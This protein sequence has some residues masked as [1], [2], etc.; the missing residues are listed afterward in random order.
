MATN[1]A[2]L[3]QYLNLLRA[4]AHL[5]IGILVAAVFIAGVVTYFSPNMYTATTKLIFEFKGA[6]PFAADGGAATLAEST[7]ITTQIGIIQSLNVAKEVKSTLT[8]L[9]QE[10]L[11]ASLK[12]KRTIFQTLKIRFTGAIKSIFKDDKQNIKIKGNGNSNGNSLEIRDAYDW[13]TQALANDL[14]VTPVFETRIVEVSYESTNPQIAAIMANKFTEAYLTTN[15]KMMIDPARKTK[16]WFDDQLKVLRLKLEEAQSRLTEYQ[17]KEG[18]VFS[19]ERLDTETSRLQR[20]SAQLVEAQQT[21]RSAVIDQQKLDDVVARGE[22]L[23]TLPMVLN[24]SV[25]QSIKSEIRSLESK[26]VELSSK[27]GSNHPER[28]KVSSELYAA[29]ERLNAEVDAIAEGV[30]KAAELSR[31]RED[32][33]TEALDSQKQLVLDLK[34][35]RDRISVYVREVASAEATYNAA[36]EQLNTTSMQSVV[37]QAN[38]SIVDRANI[39][40]SPSSPNVMKNLAIGAF[41]GMILG[42]GFVIAMNLMIRRVHSKEEL[43]DELGLPVL[44]QLNKC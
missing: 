44:G 30:R 25:F 17:Q 37:D 33:L 43:A 41:G 7:Y 40:R 2:S 4:K 9:E 16:V 15:L 24:N 13:L 38:V 6:N 1:E 12:A 19:D 8:E 39:P 32:D 42:I 27:L 3:D 10:R 23:A 29:R 28:K 11:I 35:E 22:S 5:I 34:Q 18:I 31:E 26:L 14:T 36:L 20:L 21:T